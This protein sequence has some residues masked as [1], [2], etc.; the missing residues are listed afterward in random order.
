MLTAIKNFAKRHKKKLII[1][2]V[3]T[4]GTYC[5]YKV[6]LPKLQEWLLLRLL[7]SS[8]GDESLKELFEQMSKGVTQSPEEAA[9]MKRA[10]FLHK[11][12]VSDSYVRRAL[13]ALKVRHHA[14]FRADDCSKALKEAQSKEEKQ[15]CFKALQVE[16]I[17]RLLSSTY[18]LN[19]VLLLHR[20]EF[21][22]VGREIAAGSDGKALLA[23]DLTEAAEKGSKDEDADAVHAAFFEST[24]YVQEDG[25]A[26]IADAVREAVRACA[27]RSGVLPWKPVTAECLQTHLL[28]ACAEVDTQ[29]L[30]GDKASATLLPDLVER[31]VPAA[32]KKKVKEFLDEA[33]DYVES[34]NFLAAFQALMSGAIRQLVSS[35]SDGAADPA[36]APLSDGKSATLGKLFGR[37]LELSLTVLTEED[38][39]GLV[40]RFDKEPVLNELCEALYFQE[41]R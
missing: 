37:I 29:V 27:E 21:N 7:K 3:F 12:T 17:G 9:A 23:L 38:T 39:A 11:Q 15:V 22:I 28:E 30:C 20:V 18:V 19:L 25:L 32:Q 6:L 2:A 31:E 41:S 4:G 34:P 40:A 13:P 5:A 33:R 36:D 8:E 35:L 16:A 1:T 10:Q 26:R 24:R 14:C